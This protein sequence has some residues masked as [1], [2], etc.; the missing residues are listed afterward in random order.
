MSDHVIP[1]PPLQFNIINRWTFIKFVEH[2]FDSSASKCFHKNKCMN[3]NYSVSLWG[4]IFSGQLNNDKFFER[5]IASQSVSIDA[6]RQH[7][8]MWTEGNRAKKNWPADRER[9]YQ[10]G[11]SVANNLPV[12]VNKL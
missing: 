1:S 11:L 9:K 2:W 7:D 8:L 3:K 10:Y 6:K 4:D 12:K 5:V